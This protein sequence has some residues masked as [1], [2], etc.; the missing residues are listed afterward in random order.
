MIPPFPKRLTLTINDQI[1][2]RTYQTKQSM[3]FPGGQ[4]DDSEVEAGDHAGHEYA[5]AVVETVAA[6]AAKDGM[7]FY[8]LP[9][10]TT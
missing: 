9:I 3:R 4:G 1:E 7:R 8:L 10:D 5:A 6:M 2:T